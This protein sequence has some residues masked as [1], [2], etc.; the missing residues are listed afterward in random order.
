MKT[1]GML[2]KLMLYTVETGSVTSVTA[3]IELVLFLT[4]TNEYFYY[5]M[6]VFIPVMVLSSLTATSISRS[7]IFVSGL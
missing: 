3:L 4:T 2:S 6:W 7:Y 5:M 1:S